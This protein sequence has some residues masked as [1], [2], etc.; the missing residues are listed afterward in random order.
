VYE[1]GEPGHVLVQ[2][3]VLALVGGNVPEGR[4]AYAVVLTDGNNAPQY[5]PP[6]FSQLR[7]KLT[8]TSKPVRVFTIAYGK[9]ADTRTDP[10]SCT[11]GKKICETYLQEIAE[12]SH[13]R[14]YNARDPKTISNIL[15]NV[16]SNF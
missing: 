14:T 9:D 16:I 6:A 15:T 13:A 3:V 5:A 1:R 2:V 12:L 8:D 7:K 11:D 4:R 10:D